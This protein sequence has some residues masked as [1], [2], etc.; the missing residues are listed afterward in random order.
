MILSI[1]LLRS[2]GLIISN[3]TLTEG[4]AMALSRHNR[5]LIGAVIFMVGMVVVGELIGWEPKPPEPKAPPQPPARERYVVGPGLLRPGYIMCRREDALSDARALVRSGRSDM[6]SDIGCI[7]SSPKHDAVLVD[8]GVWTS[9]VR[10]KAANGV[11]MAFF[12]A[13]DAL[14]KKAQ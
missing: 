3:V 9:E 10:L 2:I 11:S 4:Y 12:V 7:H 8:F 6:I 14:V 5:G 13:N 1:P